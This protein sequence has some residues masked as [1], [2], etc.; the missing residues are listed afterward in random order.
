MNIALFGASGKVGQQVLE[1]LLASGHHVRAFVHGTAPFEATD[2]LTI[3]KGDVHSRQDISRA[4]ESTDAVISCLG[5]WGTPKK[6]ILSSAMTNIIP[7]MEK[8]GITRIISLTGSGAKAPNET[9]RF[10][11]TL[12]RQLLLIAAGKVLLDGESHIDQLSKSDL[13]WTVL[14]SPVMTNG[15]SESYRLS[16]H[17]PLPTATIARRAVARAIVDQLTSDSSFKQA[18]HLHR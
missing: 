9:L 2:H 6:D 18:P 4:L 3:I 1:R 16:P 10:I 5:S 8:R 17:A 12:N 11:D 14:R 13:N 7:E 15:S